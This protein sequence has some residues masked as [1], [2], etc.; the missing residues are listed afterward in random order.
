MCEPI[1]TAALI[2]GGTTAATSIYQGEK[3]RKAQHQAADQAR[4]DA[5]QAFNR[6][7]PKKPDAAAM[8]YGNQQAGSGG[9]GSTMLTG[10]QGIDPSTLSLGKSTLLGGG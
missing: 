1:T 2:L 10:S 8:L 4:R 3:A 7:N 9:A 5:D 6:A